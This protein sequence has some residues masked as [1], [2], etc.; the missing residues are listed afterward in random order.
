[1]SL[2]ITSRGYGVKTLEMVFGVRVGT[3]LQHIIGGI[4]QLKFSR[5]KIIDIIIALGLI[6]RKEDSIQL[7]MSF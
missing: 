2:L 1:M 7:N 3:S 4:Y 5:L 6:L